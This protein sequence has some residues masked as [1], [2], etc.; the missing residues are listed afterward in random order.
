MGTRIQNNCA[1]CITCEVLSFGTQSS[2][3]EICG[4]PRSRQRA[5]QQSI[6]RKAE[7][8]HAFGDLA[9]AFDPFGAERALGVGVYGG[10]AARQCDAVPHQINIHGSIGLPAFYYYGWLAF[11]FLMTKLTLNTS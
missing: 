10:V 11:T 9:G 8:A 3:D 1:I 7:P 5:G 6:E 4:L 2:A